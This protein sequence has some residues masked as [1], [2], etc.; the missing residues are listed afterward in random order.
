ML[1]DATRFYIDGRWVQPH[2][3]A[4]Q[5]VID[6]STE[7]SIGEVA[8]GTNDDVDDAVAAARSAFDAYSQ[9]SVAERISWL[10]AINAGLKERNDEIAAAIS[11]E[12][13][14]PEQLAKRAQA[15]SGTQH[16]DEIVRVL[17]SFKF[18]EMQG[19]TLIRR[20]PIGVCVLISPWNWPINQ[21]ATKVAPALAAGC[22]MVLKPSEVAPLD[23]VILAEIIDAAGV[24]AGVFN[25]IQG[26]GIEIGERLTS[27]P[28]VD[29]ISFTGSTRAGVAISEN[30]APGVKRVALE[31]GGKSAGIV[32]EDA[33]LDDAVPQCVHAAMSNT[34]QSC[35]ALTRLLVPEHKH[36]EIA[37]RVA[38]AASEMSV[39][40]PGSGA[41]LGPIANKSQHERVGSMIRKGIDDGAELLAGGV[42]RPAG[43]DRGFFV[44]PT[45]FGKVDRHMTIAREEIFGPVLA[46]IAYRDLDE[47]IDI[48]NDSDYG[49]SGYVWGADRSRAVAVAAE[50]RT[51]MVHI[52]GAPL[53]SSAPF[54]GYKKSG[55]GREWGEFGLDEFLEYKSIYG[56][57]E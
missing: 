38:L 19:T 35:N 53:D 44:Q 45:V 28:E 20:E 39:G 33:N 42:D 6:P 13:G 21:I 46:V 16:F 24:P 14:A 50:L 40:A 15:P 41:H 56:A 34:G 17:R 3:S 57:H 36:D 54:G 1:P 31:L 22:T 7:L 47:A 29:M 18:E 5:A 9:S 30:A 55:N 48:A 43:L 23:A 8:L 12:M 26:T 37:E 11:A 32:L 25:L 49:L 10:E 52:N 27:H 4:R 51:G 2:G